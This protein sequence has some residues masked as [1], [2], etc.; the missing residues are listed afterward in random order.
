MCADLCAP[1]GTH[2]VTFG[3][4]VRCAEVK[5]GSADRARCSGRAMTFTTVDFVDAIG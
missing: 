3:A 2:L 1:R 4:R 5:R